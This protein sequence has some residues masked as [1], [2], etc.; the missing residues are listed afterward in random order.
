VNSLADLARLDTSITVIEA[1]DF[2]VELDALVDLAERCAAIGENDQR[3]IAGPLVDQVKAADVI[4]VNWKRL[5]TGGRCLRSGGKGRSSEN[6]RKRLA[7]RDPGR[8]AKARRRISPR[9]ARRRFRSLAALNRLRQAYLGLHRVIGDGSVRHAARTFVSA[10]RQDPSR[11]RS[12]R[13][14][15]DYFRDDRYAVRQ[16][17]S[18]TE[19]D[20]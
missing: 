11:R 2:P 6:G 1:V 4:V 12:P 5:P 8:R 14:A 17:P 7:E 16:R 10:R 19:G 18:T 20:A 15:S 13:P 3:S 9:K